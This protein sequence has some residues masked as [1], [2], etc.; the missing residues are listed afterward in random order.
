MELHASGEDYLAAVLILQKRKGM[1][2]SIDLAR[3]LGVSKPSVSHAVALL[4]KGGFLR[5]N[6]A[7][8][9]YLTQIGTEAAEK[10]LDRRRFFTSQLTA[11]GVDSRTAE[12]DACRIEHA[13][14]DEN[15]QKLKASHLRPAP[16]GDL[17]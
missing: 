15:I 11:A 5:R 1:V 7:C 8:F 14:S 12:Q 2:R 3:H 9:L 6:G 4:E 10:L 13:I 17:N 16:G